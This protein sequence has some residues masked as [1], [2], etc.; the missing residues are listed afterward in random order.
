MPKPPNKQGFTIIEVMIVLAIAGLILLIVFLAIP[1]LERSARNTQRKHDAQLIATNRQI[2]DED[3]GQAVMEYGVGT[4]TGDLHDED[5]FG[6]FCLYITQGLSYYTPPE[7]TIINNGYVAP[8]SYPTV[9]TNTIISESFLT[10]NSSLSAP[11]TVGA[12][13]TDAVVLYAIEESNG[14]Q[15]N[16]CIPSSIFTT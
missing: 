3:N 10:C 4:C 14:Q 15:E 8:T 9:T 13:P 16:L 2:Y 11:T 5:G 12:G 7:V 6:T 1:S